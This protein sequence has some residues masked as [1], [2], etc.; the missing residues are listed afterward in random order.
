MRTPNFQY[1][2]NGIKPDV[3]VP[4]EPD[5][6]KT[7]FDRQMGFVLKQIEENK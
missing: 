3:Y 4:I 2:P 7:K 1:D 6:L 5:D